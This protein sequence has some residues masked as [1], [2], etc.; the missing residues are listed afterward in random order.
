MRY[1]SSVALEAKVKLGFR[2]VMLTEEEY[3]K[4]E[5]EKGEPRMSAKAEWDR[6]EKV[7]KYHDLKGKGGK[8][9]LPIRV[10][11]FIIGYEAVTESH[12]ITRG[13]KQE[14]WSAGKEQEMLE[15]AQEHAPD[16]LTNAC[17]LAAGSHLQGNRL[18]RSALHLL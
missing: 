17:R 5:E 12:S 4:Q 6:L 10:E 16:M 14:K 13:H 9:R 8:L 15:G 11:D 1:E 2:A 7:S 18:S 3:L